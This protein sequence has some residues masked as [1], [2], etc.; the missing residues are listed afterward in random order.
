M[1]YIDAEEI[2]INKMNETKCLRRMPG[3]SPGKI[4]QTGEED[5][6]INLKL[7]VNERRGREPYVSYN[8][9]KLNPVGKE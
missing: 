8:S 7:P 2:T 6:K 3:D 5:D 4:K 1:S 9:E